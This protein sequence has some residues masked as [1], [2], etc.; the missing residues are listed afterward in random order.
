LQ[1]QYEVS[2]EERRRQAEEIERQLQQTMINSAPVDTKRRIMLDGKEV[3]EGNRGPIVF[4]A[5]RDDK[6]PELTL[7]ELIVMQEQ[8]ERQAAIDKAKRE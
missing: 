5:N 4:G 1:P 3:K 6:V 2:E 7:Q 8:A